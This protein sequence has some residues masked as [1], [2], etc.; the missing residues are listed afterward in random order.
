MIRAFAIFVLLQAVDFGTTA[1]VLALGGVE[2]NPLVQHFMSV[3]P[4]QG[5]ALAKLVAIAIG[6][7]CFLT[8]KY[9][10]LR[11]ANFA[12][13]GIAIWNASIIARL[14]A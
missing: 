12:F 9:R 13:T 5:L 4:F 11:L 14:L 3:G 10:A 8:R 7:G 6:L 2:Q 1:T